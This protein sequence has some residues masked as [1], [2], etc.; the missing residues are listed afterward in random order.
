MKPLA[1]VTPDSRP[2]PLRRVEEILDWL[3]TAGTPGSGA[4]L[5]QIRGRRG[6]EWG[7][8]DGSRQRWRDI[9]SD[10]V[11]ELRN[12]ADRYDRRLGR[13]VAEPNRKKNPCG[14]CGWGCRPQ[15][16]YCDG[17]GALLSEHVG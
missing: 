7:M 9:H 5:G 13:D 10:L 15:A 3:I 4:S 6:S 11:N 8:P 12:L 17:C 14:K 16:I 2:E 1:V